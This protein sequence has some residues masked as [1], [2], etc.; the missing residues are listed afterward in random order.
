MLLVALRA[1]DLFVY[2]LP[3]IVFA[4]RCH[5]YLELVCLSPVI[6]DVTVISLYI[7][8]HLC[9]FFGLTGMMWKDLL[10]AEILDQEKP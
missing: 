1:S 2:A 10:L 7:I 8:C 9:C 6:D 3:S 4:A 5:T